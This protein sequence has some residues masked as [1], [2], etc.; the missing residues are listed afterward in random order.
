MKALDVGI[1]LDGSGSVGQAN[2]KKAL[3]FLAKLVSHFNVSPRGTHVGMITYNG[4]P[5]MEFSLAEKNFHHLTSLKQRISSVGYTG[6]WTFTDKALSLAAQ[7]LFISRGGDRHG[8]QNVLILLTD[9][10]TS[11]TSIPYPEVLKPL[12]V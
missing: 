1:V 8:V 11:S 10:M 2:F 7:S 4:S 9:G 6:G 3:D 12:Q 5:T